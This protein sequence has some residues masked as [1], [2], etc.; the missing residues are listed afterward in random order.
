MTLQFNSFSIVLLM[1]G[2]AALLTALLIF[3]RIGGAVRWFATMMI[4]VSVWS[5]FYALELS[6][7]ELEDMLFWIR[8]E[9]IGISFLPAT[10]IMFV[11]KFVGKQEWLTLRNRIIIFGFP[12]LALLFVWT[13]SW[14]HIHYKSVSVDNSGPFPLLAITTGIWYQIHTVYFY[15]MMFWGIAL[16]VKKFKS[17]SKIYRRQNSSIIIGAF[18]PWIFNFIYLL[19]IRPF[20]HIDLTPYAFIITS[21]VIGIGLLRFS[22]FDLIPIAREKIIENM[23]EGMLIL[24]SKGRVIDANKKIQKI[25]EP[26]H[27][28]V[29]GK[30]LKEVFPQEGYLHE[31]IN[32]RKDGRIDIRISTIESTRHFEVNISSITDPNTITMG[33]LLIFSD[34]TERIMAQSILQQQ[35]DEMRSLNA[36][37]DKLFT[38]ISHDLRSPLASLTSI[39]DLAES[40]DLSN[41]EF[42][43]FLPSLAD[44]VENTSRLIENLLFWSKSQLEGETIYPE[45]F[46]LKEVIEQD[47]GFFMGKA[48]EKNLKLTHYLAEPYLVFADK[49]MIQ[50]VIRNLITN[51]I[52]YCHEDDTIDIEAKRE[53]KMIRICVSD[54]GIG[55]SP[56]TLEKVLG[57]ESFSSLGTK[58]ERGTGL[59]LMLCRDFIV[60]NK[61]IFRVES[62]E[63]KGSTFCFE[64][65]VG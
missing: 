27:V 26:F 55:M 5:V 56:E 64:L 43:E 51:A 65:P 32:E 1:S 6:C 21:I 37:K 11:V 38:I 18:I 22:L 17:S 8:L 47:I 61:G 62:E 23:R 16:L 4:C 25:L 19:G 29:I 14:H 57:N 45:I 54:S 49:S 58:K 53:D 50:L 41:E 31:K 36:V 60:K 9:Y 13:N 3:Q 39:L 10:W 63:G 28:H 7:S 33:T 15:F 2:V 30:T 20:G 24:D 48:S 42:Q 46:D 59:G 12:T 44:N 34:I 40:G 35:A 52:K